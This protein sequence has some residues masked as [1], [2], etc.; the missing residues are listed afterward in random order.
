MQNFLIRKFLGVIILLLSCVP[1]VQAEEVMTPENALE[2]EITE[3]LTTDDSLLTQVAGLVK[4]VA[5]FLIARTGDNFYTGSGAEEEIPQ[6]DRIASPE[7]NPLSSIKGFEGQYDTDIFTGGAA[8]TYPLQIPPGR[9]G[10]QPSINLGYSSHERRFDSL[11]GYGWHLPTNAIFRSTP[12]GIDQLYTDSVFSADIF[13]ATSELIAVDSVNGKYT[14][15]VEGSFID[16]AFSGESWIATDTSGTKYTFGTSEATRQDGG[17]EKVYKWMLERVED[18]NENFLTITY[19]KDNRQIYPDTIRYTGHGSA[20]GI[21]EV[22]FVREERFRDVISFNTGFHV[23]TR[24]RIGRIEVYSYHS[25]VAELVRKYDFDYDDTDSTAETLALIEVKSNSSSLPSTRFDYYDGSESTP[26]QR[27]HL[28]K[29]ITY[30]LSGTT[31]LVYQPS[32]AYRTEAQDLANAG[33]PFTIHTIHSQTVRARVGEPSYTTTYDYSGGHYFFDHA[34]SYK[35]EY[36][37]FHT[38]TITDPVG[39]VN[40]KYFHQSE[41][42]EDNSESVLLGEFDDHIAKKG[43]IY[44]DEYFDDSENFFAVTIN[45]WGKVQLADNDPESE[46][47]FPFLARVTQLQFD[48]GVDSRATAQEFSYDD[49]GNVTEEINYGEVEVSNDAGDFTD[50]LEDRIIRTNSYTQNGVARIVALPTQTESKDFENNVIYGQRTYYDDLGLGQVEKGNPTTVETRLDATSFLT[51][52]TQYN[53]YGLP[54]QVTNPRN[55]TTTFTYGSYNLYPVTST[56]PTGRLTSYSYDYRFGSVSETTDPNGA[57]SKVIFD[58][59]GRLAEKQITDPANPTELRTAE[60]YTYNFNTVPA[61]VQ[62]EVFTGNAEISILGKSYLDG[63]GR[64]I[65]VRSE[66]EDANQFVASSIIYDARG[67]V[68]KEL[69][70]QAEAGITFTSIDV[71]QPGTVY[72]Y[73]TLNRVTELT[74]SLGSTT[75]TY[76]LWEQSVTDPNGNQ[77]DFVF[78]ARKRLVEVREYLN[79]TAYSTHYSY[80]ANGN[81]IKITDAAEKEKEFTYDLLGRQLTAELLHDPSNSS[82][83]IFTFTYDENGNL[84]SSN[85]PKGQVVI[86]SYDELDR[87]LTETFNSEV[88]AT[89]V[90]DEGDYALGRLSSVVTP[91]ISKSF[92]YDILGRIVSEEK[93]IDSQ[94]Y[95]TAFTYDLLGNLLTLTYPSNTIIGY[96]YN[97]AGQVEIIQKDGA[98]I[99]TNFAYAPTGA[100][101]QIDYANGVSTTNTYDVDQLYRL[102]NKSTVETQDLASLQELDYIFDPVGNVTRIIDSSETNAAKTADYS[103]DDLYRLTYVNVS[104]SANNENYN[105]NYSYGIT[106]NITDRS[107]VGAYSYA[108]DHPQAVSSAGIRTFTYDAKGNL[109][110]DGVFTHNWDHQNRLISS[111][112]GETTVNYSYDESGARIQKTNISSGENTIYVNRFFDIENGN[113]KEHVYAGE[114]KVATSSSEVATSGNPG[115][116][117][118]PPAA[119]DWTITTSCTFDGDMAAT[120][121]VIVEPTAVLTIAPGAVLGIDFHNQKLLVRS[122]GGVLVQQG[123][124][125]R[126]SGISSASNIVYHHSD[127]LSGSNVETD[128]NG[129][130][131]ELL[132]YYPYGSVRLDEKSGTYEN[133]YKFTGKELDEDTNLYYYGARYYDSAIGRFVSVDPWSGDLTNPQTLNKYSYVLNNPLKYVDPSGEYAK[134]VHY[135]L[136]FAL[137]IAT[138]LS[139]EQARR[140]AFHNQNT[141]EHIRTRPIFNMVTGKTNTYHFSSREDARSNFDLL[142]SKIQDDLDYRTSFFSGYRADKIFGR[143]LHTFQDT[144]S[145]EGYDSLTHPFANLASRSPDRTSAAPHRALK[146]AE[147]TFFLLGRYNSVYNG[148]NFD[149]DK[150][151]EAWESIKGTVF[152]YLKLDDKSDTK[153]SDL[154]EKSGKN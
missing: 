82:P 17:S 8:F 147:E 15:K 71:N 38:V 11:I 5:S 137:G 48:G 56:D 37:G 66:V 116:G 23:E 75:T 115:S 55:F 18:R 47:H 93:T 84:L 6:P 76:N 65:Q 13:G 64:Q 31:E 96:F 141:D 10:I 49:F 30:P 42:A 120:G 95:M 101:T 150:E 131:I 105:R 25:G 94:S 53:S 26:E 79:S 1:V 149:V 90:Y 133:D 154:A 34:D 89:Y 108:A 24:Y 113:T 40:K 27:I 123:G 92:T 122:G 88:Q 140:I 85:D 128:A 3:N 19:F 152:E 2:L 135:D 91:D 107:D 58:S 50:I 136:T 9:K 28:L 125:L 62:T 39:N 54:T 124:S 114:L 83:G 142:L 145:H 7:V 104:A 146:M 43:R 153:I 132:D 63:F 32:V 130:V 129:D 61:S 41:F 21:Y 35:R 77:K 51:T 106:G 45:K 72:N 78:D 29:K 127:H 121:G 4:K 12:K 52:Q 20:P 44:R 109:I 14:P 143:A 112:D 138:G 119:G 86:Y 139:D 117:C 67:N 70:P 111:I 57:R 80:D 46:R 59:L 126:Q 98:N 97:E 99:V 103:Y 74:T 36:A 151:R 69:L 22:K 110:S 87:V 118:R 144:Y 68:Q 16:F 102:T 73:D 134:D 33:L 81:L 60:S 148:T 100:L